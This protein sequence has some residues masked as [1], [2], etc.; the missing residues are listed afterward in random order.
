MMRSLWLQVA[1]VGFKTGP[2]K[3]GLW[4]LK[5]CLWALKQCLWALKK[6]L[7]ALEHCRWDLKQ[8]LGFKTAASVSV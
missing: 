7:W 6:R 3:Q 1:P 2:L 8:R 4:A 5:Q